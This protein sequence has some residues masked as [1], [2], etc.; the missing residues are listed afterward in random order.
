MERRVASSNRPTL[1]RL[2]LKGR[3]IASNV[4]SY[5]E[6]VAYTASIR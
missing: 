1:A 4:S 6:V 5:K 2:T 3:S